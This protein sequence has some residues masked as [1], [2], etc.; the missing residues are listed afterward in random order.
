MIHIVYYKFS[1]H[2]YTFTSFLFP[3]FSPTPTTFLSTFTCQQ[4]ILQTLFNCSCRRLSNQSH[5]PFF[6]FLEV[7]LVLMLFI[8]LHSCCS[9]QFFLYSNSGVPIPGGVQEMSGCGTDGHSLVMEPC[10]PGRGLD[11]M[12]WF[13]NLNDSIILWSCMIFSTESLVCQLLFVTHNWKACWKFSF[14][15]RKYSLWLCS[16]LHLALK[17]VLWSFQVTI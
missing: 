12:I 13:Y 4:S 1:H 7:S 3:A 16:P 9:E 2:L 17:V 11:L 15:D 6:L 8:L 14:P 10:R 5:E